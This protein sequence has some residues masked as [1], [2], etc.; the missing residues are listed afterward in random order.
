MIDSL[1]AILETQKGYRLFIMVGLTGVGK[2]TV[3]NRLGESGVSFRLL[4]NRRELTDEVIISELRKMDGDPPTQVS[5]RLKRFEYAARFRKLH[6]GG[7]A[8]ALSKLELETDG[9]PPNLMF[10]GL[11]GIEETS[12]AVDFFPTARFIVLTA[13]DTVRLSR[14]M[15]RGDAFDTT[16]VAENNPKNDLIQS[17]NGIDGIEYVFTDKDIRTIATQAGKNRIA[18]DEVIKKTTIIVNERK[19]YDPDGTLKV[20]KEKLPEEHRIV[21]DTSLLQPAEIMDRIQDWW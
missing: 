18:F 7:M 8:Y 16:Q 17:M 2:T 15:G 19:N 3:I 14:L 20:L 4:P 11:R 1:E 6:P 9:L 5:D 13:P 12:H 21:F 10:D